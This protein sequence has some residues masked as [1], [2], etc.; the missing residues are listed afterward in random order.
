MVLTS[1]PLISNTSRL[2]LFFSGSK[3]LIVVAGLKG[4]G[5]FCP[6][7]YTE[8]SKVPEIFDPTIDELDAMYPS[9]PP[10]NA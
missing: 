2:T 8:G 5:K 6:S 9:A 10:I 7:E 4:L 1:F 3:K